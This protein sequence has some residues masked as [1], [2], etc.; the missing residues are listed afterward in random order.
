MQMQICTNHSCNM[1]FDMDN[2][3]KLKLNATA[4]TNAVLLTHPL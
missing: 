3:K 2:L 1:I 4:C